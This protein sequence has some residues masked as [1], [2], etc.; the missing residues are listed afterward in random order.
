M[1]DG[2]FPLHRA[3]RAHFYLATRYAMCTIILSPFDNRKAIALDR[4]FLG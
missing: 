3:V 1:K 2:P 4:A